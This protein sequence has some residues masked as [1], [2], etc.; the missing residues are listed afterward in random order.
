MYEAFAVLAFWVCVLL[1]VLMSICACVYIAAWIVGKMCD[2]IDKHIAGL[3]K[4][5]QKKEEEK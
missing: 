4:H 2:S 5:Q 1:A 3:F